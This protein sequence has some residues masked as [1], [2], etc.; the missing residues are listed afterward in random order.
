ML[1][2]SHDNN[3]GEYVMS[4]SELKRF[5]KNRK[6]N[7]KE[8]STINHSS[9]RYSSIPITIMNNV[10]DNWLLPFN[11]RNSTKHSMDFYTTYIGD[12]EFIKELNKENPYI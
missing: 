8:L 6:T 3:G 10:S 4:F 12:L 11:N 7:I 1:N 2:Y 5:R 9:L